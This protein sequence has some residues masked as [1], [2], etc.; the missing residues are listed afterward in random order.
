MFAT[1]ALSFSIHMYIVV[2]TKAPKSMV[3]KDSSCCKKLTGKSKVKSS[4]VE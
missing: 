3:I 1:Y 4:I 2:D